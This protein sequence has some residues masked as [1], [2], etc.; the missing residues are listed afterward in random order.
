MWKGVKG[1]RKVLKANK[2]LPSSKLD[3]SAD[4]L[5]VSS[6]DDYVEAKDSETTESEDNE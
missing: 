4:V 3:E 2:T 6:D 1:L 5:T